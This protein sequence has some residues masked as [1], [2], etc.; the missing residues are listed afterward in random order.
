MVGSA[1][2]SLVARAFA[3]HWTTLVARVARRYGDLALAEDSA[4]EAFALAAESWH[5]DPPADAG[6]WLWVVT[7]RRAVDRIRREARFAQK[8]PL[9]A[10]PELS[11]VAPGCDVE[12]D[13]L[14]L[15][16]GCCHPSLPRSAQVALTLRAV[17]GLS[18]D[19]IAAVL[20]ERPG[21]VTRRLSRAREK[22]RANAVPFEIPEPAAWSH[23]LDVVLEAVLLTFTAG[24]TNRDGPA[25]IRGDLC[26]E[27]R[28]LIT[29]I[30]RLAPD[31]AEVLGLAALTD[32]TDARRPGRT[33]GD[34]N[35]VLMAEQDRSL[36][37]AALIASG[38]DRLTAALQQRRLGTFQI[39]AALS[40]CHTLS[41]SWEATDW[42]EIVRWY[43]ALLVLDDRPVTRLNRAAALTS[44]GS[45]DLALAALRRIEHELQHSPHYWVAVADACARLG[46]VD[47]AKA[48]LD[49]ATREGLHADESAAVHRRI[50][51]LLDAA[52]P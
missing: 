27:A 11:T 3:E 40:A 35:A 8:L 22:L 36:W 5:R 6:S 4:A 7:Q 25:L 50:E 42:A 48:A 44:A 38:R 24:Q 18:T 52:H 34:G 37:D 43:D 46:D 12:T 15:L 23:R 31:D 2:G 20:N 17:N 19:Q 45:A 41:P 10:E 30:E 26:D 28:W 39:Q 21:T 1:R 47:S 32:F 33:D 13:H 14:A 29:L 16:F 49:R 9:L 51:A